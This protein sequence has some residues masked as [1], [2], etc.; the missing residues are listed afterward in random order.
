[1]IKS[2][3]EYSSKNTSINKNKVPKIYKEVE[4]HHGWTKGSLNLD[5]GGG[6]YDTLSDILKKN[7]DVTNLIYDPFNR[8]EYHNVNIINH[9]YESKADTVTISNV[10]NV[11][12]EKKERIN[13]LHNAFN[14][15]KENGV[16]YITVY[17]GNCSGIGKNTRKDQFQLNHKSSWYL[18]EVRTVF[19]SA[20]IK[21]KL[22]FAK[23]E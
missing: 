15:L 22:I 11:I 4:K 14:N 7:D 6:K 2:N 1:M 21:G 8:S 12:K 19:P 3:Q 5:I 16:L 10:L 13:I 18:D 17:E 20:N 23:K 9:L